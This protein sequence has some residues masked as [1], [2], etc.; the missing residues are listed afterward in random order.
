[1]AP[2]CLDTMICSLSLLISVFR[3]LVLRFL[4]VESVMIRVFDFVTVICSFVGGDGVA[5]VIGR[6]GVF[7]DSVV[8]VGGGDDG[9]GNVGDGGG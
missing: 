7:V 1:M 6:G 5:T 4:H 9:G 2:G 8:S 3:L